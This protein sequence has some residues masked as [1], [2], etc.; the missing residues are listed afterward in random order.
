[1]RLKRDDLME[2][3]PNEVRVTSGTND[4]SMRLTPLMLVASERCGEQGSRNVSRSDESKGGKLILKLVL[5]LCD[6]SIGSMF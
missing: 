2:C 1:M 5:L 3:T 4:P 6:E